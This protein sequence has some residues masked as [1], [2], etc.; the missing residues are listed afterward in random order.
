[1]RRRRKNRR[2]F[3]Y[4]PEKNLRAFSLPEKNF[5]KIFKSQEQFA[6]FTLFFM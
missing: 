6:F 4:S 2:R 5:E 1:M 3:S